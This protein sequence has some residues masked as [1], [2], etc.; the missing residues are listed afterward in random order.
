MS[1]PR[2]PLLKP[3]EYFESKS[4]S[5]G[6]AVVVVAL[7]TVVTTAGVGGLLWTFTQQLDQQVSVDNPEHHPEHM[8][9]QYEPGGA[10]DDID[11]PPGCDA[12]VSETVD[13]RLGDMVWQEVS[14]LIPSVLIG[15][16]LVWLFEGFFLYL[17][18]LVVGG[19]GRF[20][21]TLVVAGWGMVSKLFRLLVVVAL[22]SYQLSQLSLP[23]SP[24]GARDA[25]LGVISGVSPVAAVAVFVAIAWGT[26]IRTYGLARAHDVDVSSAAV[27]TVGLALA[28]LFFEPIL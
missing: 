11:A 6:R 7:V 16:P 17:G 4:L 5:F 23:D 18:G 26:Y 13:K 2:T 15:A 12:A 19:E 9:E 8:C 1:G 21:D 10:F 14:W 28:G 24:A 27:A 25:I 22:M 3:R 20:T